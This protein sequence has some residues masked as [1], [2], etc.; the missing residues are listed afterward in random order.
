LAWEIEHCPPAEWIAPDP[1]KEERESR[2]ETMIRK[3]GRHA[4]VNHS[5]MI[6]Q[7][8]NRPIDKA[9]L[10]WKGL[11]CDVKDYNP[12]TNLAMVAVLAANQIVQVNGHYLFPR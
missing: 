1:G 9:T 5:C 10:Q 12:Y 11:I 4:L 6:L 3:E 7:P 2:R 8:K